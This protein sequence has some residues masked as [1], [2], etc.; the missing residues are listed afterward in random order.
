MPALGW[1]PKPMEVVL[2]MR[3]SEVGE[4]A[5]RR[6]VGR[7]VLMSMAWARW[8]IENWISGGGCVSLVSAG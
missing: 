1:K 2:R 8:L 7:R 5:V 6:R 3:T 4:E